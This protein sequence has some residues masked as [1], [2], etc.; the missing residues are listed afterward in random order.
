M[1]ARRSG[2]KM[3]STT[4]YYRVYQSCSSREVLQDAFL[5]DAAEML[6][7]FYYAYWAS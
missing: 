5:L 3:R 1:A 7:A 2:G 6:M 4:I